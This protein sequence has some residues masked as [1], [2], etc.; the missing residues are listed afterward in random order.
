MKKWDMKTLYFSL[1]HLSLNTP[2][3]PRFSFI[4]CDFF[5]R[6]LQLDEFV[7]KEMKR[8]FFSPIPLAS[9]RQYHSS[10]HPHSQKFISFLFY[11]YSLITHSTLP[12]ILLWIIPLDI[13]KRRLYIL[14]R[15]VVYQIVLEFVSVLFERWNTPSSWWFFCRICIY[16]YK[17]RERERERLSSH[18]SSCARGLR[19]RYMKGP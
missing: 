9:F 7:S 13:Y 15:T 6:Y 16:I 5:V 8:I 3:T 4:S 10:L 1:L 19:P 18:T 12:A 17:K 14:V 2:T 11:F